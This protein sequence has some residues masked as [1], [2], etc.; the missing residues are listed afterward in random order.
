MRN[1]GAKI[2]LLAALLAASSLPLC[3]QATDPMAGLRVSSMHKNQW[4]IT[5]Q[6][7]DLKGDPI[8]NARIR[9][10]YTSTGFLPPSTLVADLQGKYQTVVELESSTNP[11]LSVKVSAE[12]VGF[13]PAH[14]T[15]DF[16]KA[17]ESWPIDLVM[18]PEQEDASALS[19]DELLAALLPRYQ[20]VSPPDLKTD[21]ARQSWVRA[22]GMLQDPQNSAKAVA[23]LAP[24]VS[25]SPS[26]VEC[27]T[28]LALAELRTGGLA[29]A[30]RELSAAALIKLPPAEESRL[31][32]PLLGLGVFAEWSGESAHALGLL[33]RASKL[34]PHDALALQEVGRVL[35]NQKNWEAADE[36][37]LQAEQAGASPEA[38][39]LRCRAALEE[40]DLQEA[41]QEMSTYLAGRDIKTF[42]IPV[43]TLYTQLRTQASLMGFQ[44][45][46]S[47]VDEPLPQLLKAWPEL[48][49]LEAAAD[50]SQLAAILEKTG[51]AV[52]TFFKDFQNATSRERIEE[53]KLGKDG[54]VKQALEQQ[55]QYLLLTTP[56]QGGVRLEEYRTNQDGVRIGPTDAGQGFMLTAGF[57]SASVLFYPAYQSGSKFRHLGR[58]NFHG[59]SCDVLAFA[60]VPAK[61]RMNERFNTPNGSVLVLHQGLAWI[62]RRDS[63][64]V[65]LRTDL[66]EPLPKVRL[67][68]ETT[69]INYA[70][71]RFKDLPA[72]LSLPSQVTVTVDWKGKTFQNQ[73]QYSDFRLFNTAVQEKHFTPET[74]PPGDTTP[75]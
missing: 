45:T 51:A 57:A 38:R 19:Q 2:A 3:A 7:K 62:D 34:A 5:G 23:L 14:E 4:M 63:R 52:E 32:N 24:L 47:L 49:G 58:A 70:L 26:C 53:E 73:H 16:E 8:G 55:F 20:A 68:R 65:R 25:K 69:E 35:L 33:M 31:A 21:S 11:T 48:E 75:N 29:G 1:V 39:L 36:Y 17:G 30:Q 43:R 72:P 50:Q 71:V 66:L 10:F 40:G 56:Y 61:A 37:L 74:T 44:S 12:K 9:I 42:P 28:L 22:A 18:R 13:H 27:R 64:V 46:E 6:V 54:K 41:N 67:Q 59:V 60:Q 15:A